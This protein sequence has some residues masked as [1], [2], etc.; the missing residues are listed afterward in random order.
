MR[1]RHV[2]VIAG[3][4]ALA[5]ITVR[6]ADKPPSAPQ[7]PVV[8]IPAEV[9][10][11]KEFYRAGFQISVF[12]GLITS[13]FDNER[14][15]VGFGGDYFFNKNL[16]LGAST[17]F[18]DVDGVAFDKL[19]L[20]GLVRLPIGRY[21]VYGFAG[22]TREFDDHEWALVIGPGLE[23]RITT[24][25]GAFTEIGILK[26]WTGDREVGAEARIGIRYAF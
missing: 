19:N 20:R 25:I 16:G 11:V 10:V 9:H 14:S 15:N 1:I 3:I 13:D 4:M 23:G 26:R 7:E 6:C 21:A 12:G 22:T 8:G 18:E 24:E 2:L 17:A 5:G